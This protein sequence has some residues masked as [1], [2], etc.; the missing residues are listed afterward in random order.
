MHP[1]FLNIVHKTLLSRSIRFKYNKIPI[2]LR[3]IT[4]SSPTK[5]QIKKDYN[6]LVEHFNHPLFINFVPNYEQLN[7]N[8]ITPWLYL[9]IKRN[10]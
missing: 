10:A 3:S 7:N 9:Y 1:T 6:S 8:S 2:K 4:N 5:E